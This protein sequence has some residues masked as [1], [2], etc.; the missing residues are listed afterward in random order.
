[1]PFA[2]HSLIAMQTLIADWLKNNPRNRLIFV[3]E[4]N[5][6]LHFVDVGQE[7]SRKIQSSI[8]SPNIAMIA[9]DALNEI[10]HAAISEDDMI[11][12]YVAITNWGIL[13]EDALALNLQNIFASFSQSVV[14]IAQ[15]TGT[16][17]QNRFY[18]DYPNLAYIINLDNIQHYDIY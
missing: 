3:Q 2:I 13:F 9:E 10:L 16:V 6:N 18:L 14:L 15:N 8:A 5:S 7:L 17:V 1:M 12:R 4:A 11:G